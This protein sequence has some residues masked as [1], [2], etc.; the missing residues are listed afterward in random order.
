MISFLL[1]LA[2][3]TTVYIPMTNQLETTIAHYFIQRDFHSKKKDMI[4]VS[5]I[6]CKDQ[7]PKPCALERG[8][9]VLDIHE[10]D[11]GDSKQI[12]LF[13]LN[14]KGEIVSE[15]MINKRYKIEKIPQVTNIKTTVIQ[16]GTIAPK[17]TK[18]EKPPLLVRKEAEIT[19]HDIDQAVIRL[20]GKIEK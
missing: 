6:D 16:R 11:D 1:G 2:L 9:W 13:L 3:A 18:I 14:G 5:W 15:A 4:V 8:Y 10:Y 17:K 7:D 12:N 19:S 20:L